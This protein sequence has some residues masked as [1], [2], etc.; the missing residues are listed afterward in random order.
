MILP[1]STAKTKM[2][3]SRIVILQKGVIIQHGGYWFAFG[4][5]LNIICH[6]TT[7]N[8][9]VIGMHNWLHG[10]WYEVLVP[11]AI[12]NHNVNNGTCSHIWKK[13]IITLNDHL[14]KVM[15]WTYKHMALPNIWLASICTWKKTPIHFTFF[16]LNTCHKLYVKG[17]TVVKCNHFG[18]FIQSVAGKSCSKKAANVN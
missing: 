9:I 5:C 6:K 14:I 1:R 13:S 10:L 18:Q 11:N 17:I 16:Q 8:I 4:S 7:G 15:P 12:V 3:F 2:A